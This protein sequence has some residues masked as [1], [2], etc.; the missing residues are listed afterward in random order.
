MESFFESCINGVIE[1]YQGQLQQIE[2]KGRRLKVSPSHAL[3]VY[4][5]Y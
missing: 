1:L 5:E 4:F 2:S 3:D